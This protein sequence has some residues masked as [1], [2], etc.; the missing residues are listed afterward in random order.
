MFLHNNY[1]QIFIFVTSHILLRYIY[2]LG[3]CTSGSVLLYGGSSPN[4]G[5]VQIC[6]DGI[7][8]GVCA[9][10]WDEIDAIFTCRTLRYNTGKGSNG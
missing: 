7:W 1:I 4:E 2:Y 8:V 9:E 3:S 6:S 10:G 5:W